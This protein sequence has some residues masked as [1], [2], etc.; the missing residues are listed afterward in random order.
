[1]VGQ[2][3]KSGKRRLQSMDEDNLP[4]TPTPMNKRSSFLEMY[5]AHHLDFGQKESGLFGKSYRRHQRVKG[6]GQVAAT[7]KSLDWAILPKPPMAGLDLGNR[8]L[9]VG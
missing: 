1:M 2:S 7:A 6:A 5:C 4:K 8:S 9:L 3:G